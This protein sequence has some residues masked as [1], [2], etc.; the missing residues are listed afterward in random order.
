MEEMNQFELYYIYTYIEMSQE[1]SLCSYLKQTKM[2][3][4]FNLQNQKTEGWNRSCLGVGSNSGRGEEVGKGNGR[5]YIVQTLC[6]HVHGKI[7][8][9]E[10]IPG[11]GSVK[12]NDG[13]DEFNYI[14]DIW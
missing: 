6:T 4:F 14:F 12:E 13:G 10:T 8:P 11:M 2:S 1:N 5:V 7:I 3:F 9:V